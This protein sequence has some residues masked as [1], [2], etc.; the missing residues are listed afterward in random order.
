[1]LST[2]RLI[3]KRHIT[4]FTALL[5]VLA[6]CHCKPAMA[7]ENQ[8]MAANGTNE[9]QAATFEQAQ[10]PDVTNHHLERGGDGRP[11]ISL[12]YPAFGNDKVDAAM[13]AFAESQAA[14]YED[15]VREFDKPGEEKPDSYDMWDMNGIF[16]LARPNPDVVSVTFNIYSY[17]GGAHGNLFIRCLNYDLRTGAELGLN[18]LFESPE[19]ALALLAELTNKKLRQDL[20]DDVEE[21]MLQSGTA[22]EPTNFANLSLRPDGLV[23]EFQPYQVGPWSIGPQHV[24]VSLAELA[25]AGPKPEIWPAKAQT[26]DAQA[27]YEEAIKEY[28]EEVA[29]YK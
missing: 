8:N 2:L 22:P 9:E 26:R 7:E 12:Y 6:I 14:D 23:V 28:F 20:G 25:D 5:F 1:M 24:T 19:K 4:S 10:Y 27:K 29:K 17:S 16:T 11:S 15:D 21:E 3:I 18:A 13:A